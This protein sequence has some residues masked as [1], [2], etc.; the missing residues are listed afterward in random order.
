MMVSRR[1]LPEEILSDNG[2]NFK[3]ADRELKSLI[4]Q[5]D[6]T[7]IQESVANKSIKWTFNPPIAPHFGGVHETLINS[8]KKAISAILGNADINDEELTKAIIGAES[9]INSRPLTYQSSDPEDNTPLTPNHFLHGQVGGQ[10][11]PQTVQH[12]I[13]VV[14]SVCVRKTCAAYT[15]CNILQ[16]Y[17]NEI[18]K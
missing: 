4:L 7:R 14:M 2:T 13:G 1:G 15:L 11:T 9:L 12:I 3:G 8:T 18:N 17:L 10:L 6:E 16:A 5:L